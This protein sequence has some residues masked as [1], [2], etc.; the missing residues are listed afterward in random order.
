MTNHLRALHGFYGER[1]GVRIARKLSEAKEKAVFEIK[2]RETGLTESV[3]TAA[4]ARSRSRSTA[5]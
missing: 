5:H 1:Q 4:N 2:N 3:P